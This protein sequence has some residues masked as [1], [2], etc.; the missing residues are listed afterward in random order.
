MLVVFE[1]SGNGPRS[2]CTR[3]RRRI[4]ALARNAAAAALDASAHA[5]HDVVLDVC[6]RAVVIV[7]VA[8]VPLHMG[9]Q[10]GHLRSSPPSG[11]DRRD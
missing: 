8:L 3:A 9:P 7:V 5:K 11:R 6:V 10:H 2:V 1:V 4:N